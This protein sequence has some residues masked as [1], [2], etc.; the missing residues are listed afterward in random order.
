MK[1]IK[2]ILICFLFVSNQVASQTLQEGIRALEN[3]QFIKAKDIFY[4]FLKGNKATPETYFYLGNTYYELNQTDSSK[5]LYNKGI[6]MFPQSPFNYIGLGKLLLDVNNVMESKVNFNKALALAQ[7]KD[8]RFHVLIAEAFLFGKNKDVPKAY[9]ML[10]TAMS[11]DSRNPDIYIALGDASLSDNNG[12]MAITNYEKALELN[13]KMAK[14]NA[15]IGVVYTRSRAYDVSE[16]AFNDA[17][18]ADPDYAPAY[19]DL[20]DLYYNF[21]QYEKARD[22][23]QLYMQRTDSTVQCLT[24]YAYILF[25]SKDYANEITIINQLMILDSTNVVLNRLLAYAF[26]EQ[27]KYPEGLRYIENFFEKHDKN[28]I[29]PMDYEYYGKLLAKM[30]RDTTS[31]VNRDSMAILNLQKALEMDSSKTE[32]NND[33]GDVYMRSKKYIQAQEAYLKKISFNKNPSAIDYF[34]LGKSYY[35]NKEYGKGDSAFIKVIELKPTASAGYLWRAR[36]N[37]LN[38]AISKDTVFSIYS[39]YLEIAVPDPKTPKTEI[40]EAFRY[41]GYYYIQQDDYEKAKENYNKSLEFDPENKEA[42]DILD[43]ISKQK[44]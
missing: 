22:T 35:F 8:S 43:Q 44:K 34:S 12:G 6:S 11:I 40:A 13:P 5:V 2:Y 36:T 27:K 7:P 38:E 20:S 17:L 29:I 1:T 25:L 31:K 33:I 26:Y 32:L 21:R 42:K 39:K 18:L 9:E 41:L 15:R 24:K 30:P 3:E 19:R 37:S 23:Y 28:K 16:K 10:N 14:A 4:G